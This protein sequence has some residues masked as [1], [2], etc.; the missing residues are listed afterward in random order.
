MHQNRFLLVIDFTIALV[1]GR[2]HYPSLIWTNPTSDDPGERDEE[3]E[4][5]GGGVPAQSGDD[6]IRIPPA[7][8]SAEVSSDLCWRRINSAAASSSNLRKL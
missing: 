6:A 7:A 8:D 2:D 4:D 1:V 3:D 5:D